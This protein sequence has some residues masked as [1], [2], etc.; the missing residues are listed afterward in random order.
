MYLRALGCDSASRLIPFLVPTPPHQTHA[1]PLSSNV[2]TNPD[3]PTQPR[4]F[5]DT[6]A[7]RQILCVINIQQPSPL[8]R[9]CHLK[10]MKPKECDQ[11]KGGNRI[12]ANMRNLSL[13]SRTGRQ[14]R[15]H[16]NASIIYNTCLT[17]KT[18]ASSHRRETKPEALPHD[19]LSSI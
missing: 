4:P 5:T 7:T 8:G 12:E 15:K 11:R 14:W 9:I 2:Q 17:T 1:K 16:D 10:R 6:R 13:Q 19:C 3:P 18:P